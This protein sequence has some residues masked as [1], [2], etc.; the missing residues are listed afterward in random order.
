M[1]STFQADRNI[2]KQSR[3]LKN[4]FIVL[5]NYKFM[6]YYFYINIINVR[7]NMNISDLKNCQIKMIC[8]HL[9][10]NDLL[11]F[12]LTC[13]G[14]NSRLKKIVKND[15]NIS[16]KNYIK[17]LLSQPPMHT[18]DPSEEGWL[19]RYWGLGEDC[20]WK[21]YIDGC[22]HRFGKKVFDI[23]SHGGPKEP[24]FSESMQEACEF[25]ARSSPFKKINSDWYLKLHGYTC[26]H[27]DQSLCKNNVVLMGQ[28]KVGVFRDIDDE[29]NGGFFS[30]P[31]EVKREV[32]ILNLELEK[33]MGPSFGMGQ[34]VYKRSGESIAGVYWKLMTREQV[35]KVFERFLDQFYTEIEQAA[36]P[37]DKLMAIAKFTKRNEWLHPNADGNGRTNIAAMNKL[38]V[39]HGFHPAILDY[40]YQSNSL[41][42]PLWKDYI[43][44]GM[45]KWEQEQRRK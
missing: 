42:L 14:I 6:Y 28:E 17:L 24:G 22:F 34:V 18:D 25:I 33:E 37:D 38:L 26:D 13:R 21:E 7:L 45:I 3:K 1:Q 39:D 43:R 2:Q 27:F 44:L 31:L 15:V 11:N 32:D 29:G 5:I 23:G 36:S 30:I 40:P 12:S 35:K 41:T 4:L 8:N 20:K 10:A 19:Q 9:E 16:I